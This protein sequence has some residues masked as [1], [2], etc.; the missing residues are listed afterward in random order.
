MQDTY[1]LFQTICPTIRVRRPL[2][3]FLTWLAKL[4]PYLLDN[5]HFN[6]LTRT[7]QGQITMM[8]PSLAFPPAAS[9]PLKSA[10]VTRKR[11]R[12]RSVR[13]MMGFRPN[14]E[15]R[16]AARISDVLGTQ[17]LRVDD[18][19]TQSRARMKRDALISG[20]MSGGDP[21]QL[22]RKLLQI[23]TET[24]HKRILGRKMKTPDE[25]LRAE[26]DDIYIIYDGLTR[27]IV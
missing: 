13:S 15:S 5:S 14:H 18:Q 27:R 25:A 21:F 11:Y 26:Q 23:S 17:T 20:V 10:L 24:R 22:A 7:L 3:I 9:N 19:L 2:L 6:L 16:R 4:L 1:G 12:S 8:R